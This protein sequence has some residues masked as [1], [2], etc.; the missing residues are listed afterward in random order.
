MQHEVLGPICSRTAFAPAVWHA[1]GEGD[2]WRLT[3]PPAKTRGVRVSAKREG[4]RAVMKLWQTQTLSCSFAPRPAGG[5][6]LHGLYGLAVHQLVEI[7]PTS[8]RRSLLDDESQTVFVE[9]PEPI[10]PA[11]LFQRLFAAVS[12]ELQPDDSHVLAIAGVAHMSGV[13]S[14]LSDPATDFI[15][16]SQNAR[17]RRPGDTG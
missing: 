15:V 4:K 17:L 10:V 14:A 9:F 16:T 3:A 6:L 5:R 7:A 1:D 12:R 2:R 11:D 8:T 13:S